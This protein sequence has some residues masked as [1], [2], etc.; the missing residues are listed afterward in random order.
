VARLKGEAPPLLVD[1]DI[2]LDFID[3]SPGSGDPARAACL[4]YSYI[5]DEAHRIAFHRRVAEASTGADIRALRAE[6]ADRFGLLPPPAGRL[7]RLAELRVAAAV[8]RIAR[9]EVRD[10]KV[11]LY[12]AHSRQTLLIR[13]RSPHIAAASADQKIAQLIAW[14][15]RVGAEV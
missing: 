5:E 12:R 9:I 8:H 3:L 13:N 4:P 11:G 10:G 15:E 1:V 14:V 7:L 2:Q 6:M